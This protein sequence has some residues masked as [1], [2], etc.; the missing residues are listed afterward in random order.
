MLHSS[1]NWLYSSNIIKASLK[2][3]L[4]LSAG[5]R[6]SSFNNDSIWFSMEF[7]RV[8]VVLRIDLFF[9]NFSSNLK[10]QFIILILKY[11]DKTLKAVIEA[12][13]FLLIRLYV[14]QLFLKIVLQCKNAAR[15]DTFLM[16]PSKYF[17]SFK[18]SFM[19]SC[20]V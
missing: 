6:Q 10:K 15:R 17:V 3:L 8:L 9:P 7:H 12:W 18:P 14:N 4:H 19:V 2:S 16:P 11:F 13:L 1:C 5:A 20:K